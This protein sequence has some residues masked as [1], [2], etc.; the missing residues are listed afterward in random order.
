[1]RT[2]IR[3]ILHQ[4]AA[5]FGYSC[6]TSKKMAESEKPE[7][8]RNKTITFTIMAQ[9]N[10]ILNEVFTRIDVNEERPNWCDRSSE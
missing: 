9:N 6:P 1:M 4:V 5:M 8:S 7:K 10:A 2:P 3:V